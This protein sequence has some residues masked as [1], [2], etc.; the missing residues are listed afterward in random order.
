[1][2]SLLSSDPGIIQFH[3]INNQE[4]IQTVELD[5]IVQKSSK[6]SVKRHISNQPAVQRLFQTT[7]FRTV[8]ASDETSSSSQESSS[9]IWSSK[10]FVSLKFSNI[11]SLSMISIQQQA[12]NLLK[13]G[14]ID[15]ALDLMRIIWSIDSDTSKNVRSKWMEESGLRILESLPFEA[16]R[17]WRDCA[18]LGTSPLEKIS[19]VLTPPHETTGLKDVLGFEKDVYSS[20][21]I[22]IHKALIEYLLYLQKS[23]MG[24]PSTIETALVRVLALSSPEQLIAFVDSSKTPIKTSLCDDILLKKKV[25][26]VF[27]ST[28][29]TYSSAIFC[30]VSPVF[31]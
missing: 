18:A 16:I 27:H 25:Y 8:Y 4:L 5:K 20:D 19:G 11:L 21:E 17:L 29:D 7:G 24:N 22:N 15:A 1:M 31:R 14:R 9:R 28:L 23:N 13:Q 26:F 10:F 6:P 2:I 3:Q 12:D 30:L